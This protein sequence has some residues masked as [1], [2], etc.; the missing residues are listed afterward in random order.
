MGLRAVFVDRDNTLLDDPGFIDH[1]DQVRLL[2]QAA[3]ALRRVRACGYQI[4]IV[5]NQS[6]VA[7]GLFDEAQLARVHDRLRKL[8][9]AEGVTV[10]AVYYCPYLDGEEAVVEPYRRDSDLRKPQPGML[11]QAARERDLDLSQSWMIGDRMTDIEAGAAAHCS[12]ILVGP[13]PP[14]YNGRVVPD[15]VVQSLREAARVVEE[16]QETSRQS[17]AGSA[18]ESTRQVLTEVRDALQRQQRRESQEDFSFVR[19]LGAL[20]QMLAIVVALWGVVGI[21]S[22]QHVASI[23]RLGLAIFLQLLAITVHIVERRR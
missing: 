20:M 2:P 3:E 4:I 19:L 14:E 11:L 17:E 8:L 7:R 13:T 6:G 16:Y 12:T 15:Y 18:D 1:P 21:F 23:P 5:S 10:D 22:G 9:A